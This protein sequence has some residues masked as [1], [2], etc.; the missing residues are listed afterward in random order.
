MCG[1]CLP[2]E[3]GKYSALGGF[4]HTGIFKKKASKNTQNQLFELCVCDNLKLIY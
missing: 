3:G 1:Q 4:F 2:L